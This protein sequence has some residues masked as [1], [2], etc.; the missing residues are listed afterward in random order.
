MKFTLLTFC[1]AV[2]CN[3]ASAQDYV[4]KVLIN[5]GENFKA[6]TASHKD[7]QTLKTGASLFSGD[8]I[9]VSEHAII[10]LV[11]SSGKTIELKKAGQYPVSVLNEKLGL[12]TTSVAGKYADFLIGKF[13][14]GGDTDIN[15]NHRNYL[16]VTGA[17][18][19]ALENYAITAMVPLNGEVLHDEAFIKWSDLGEENT[20]VV[21]FKN[22]FNE[23]LSTKETTKNYLTVSLNDQALEE[24]NIVIFSVSVKNK[25]S[26]KSDSYSLKRSTGT[27]SLLLMEELK[28]LQAELDSSPALREIIL[29]S[30]YEKNNLFIE[31]I[32][33]YES[34][35]AANPEIE[36]FKTSYSILKERIG[37]NL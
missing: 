22:M 29:A 13:Y 15:D 26:I 10:G 18:E 17:V 30:F 27:N 16:K 32:D 36:E 34:A 20:Y 8:I 37:I 28:L 11:H 12:L 24:E 31:A 2:I 14:E 21:S 23:V 25:T 7:K 1:L 33:K 5:K 4:F 19:R 9:T 3:W 6:T 35:I